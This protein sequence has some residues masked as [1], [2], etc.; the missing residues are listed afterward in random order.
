[1]TS[2]DEKKPLPP[3][4]FSLGGASL[5]DIA[6]IKEQILLEGNQNRRKI[7]I[8]V[9]CGVLAVLLVLGILLGVFLNHD[10]LKSRHLK[11][12]DGNQ[13]YWETVETDEDEGTDTFYTD[14]ASG[15]AAVMFDHNKDLK[16]YK[17]S[18]RDICYIVPE[19][20]GEDE[21]AKEA[22]KELENKEEGSTQASKNGGSRKMSLDESRPE[23]PE[24]SEAMGLFCGDLEPRWANIELPV[25]SSEEDTSDGIVLIAPASPGDASAEPKSRARRGWLWGRRRS[26]RRWHVSG[27]CC[28]GVSITW[29]F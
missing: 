13:L 1:M 19:D 12:R 22:A 9:T 5:H 20:E 21:K 14:S 28:W 10:P 27:Y 18:G 15:A 26:N 25:D 16:A 2:C 7:V 6:R 17:F 23:T 11:F 29:S 8:G 3:A 24:L 4:D